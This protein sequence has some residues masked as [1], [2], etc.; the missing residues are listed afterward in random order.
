[1]RW[2][3][4]LLRLAK[5]GYLVLLPDLF[6]RY[7]RYKTLVS[8]EVFRGDVRAILGPL[9]ATTGND[10]AARDTEA[11]LAYLDSRGDVAGSK[12][13]ARAPKARVDR[14]CCP[15]LWG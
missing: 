7:G 14:A 5:A 9:M 6:Y 4:L 12:L 1:M 8:K 10:K 2:Q 15:W 11:F 13:G 3:S